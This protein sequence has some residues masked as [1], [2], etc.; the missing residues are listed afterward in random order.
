MDLRTRRVTL[1]SNLATIR[2]TGDGDT[3][4]M[5]GYKSLMLEDLVKVA[6][7]RQVFVPASGK[8]GRPRKRDY[9]KALQ[10]FDSRVAAQPFRF[11]DLSPE[12]RTLVYRELLTFKRSW[13]CYPQILSTCKQVHDEAE[14]LLYGDNL[15]DIKI[16][17][18]EVQAHGLRCG[19]Y[20]PSSTSTWQP[21][22]RV[23]TI[24]W[25]SMLRKVQWLRISCPNGFHFTTAQN[26]L[27]AVQQ[28]LY[29]L[30]I[31]L[32]D[33]NQ[34]RSMEVDLQSLSLQRDS[35]DG[36]SFTWPLGMLEGL[37]KVTVRF[38][39][40]ETLGLAAMSKRHE[41]AAANPAIFKNARSLLQ[42]A[43]GYDEIVRTSRVR[44]SPVAHRGGTFRSGGMACT[45]VSIGSCSSM[46]HG[47]RGRAARS[48]R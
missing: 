5:T 17:P 37:K 20:N 27:S 32:S 4:S 44:K 36:V 11:M 10:D 43:V 40:S 23:D 12:L 42:E 6:K 29:Y 7:T 21:E 28:I 45:V 2:D 13:T 41:A 3:T 33:G 16:W 46:L 25:P 8:S 30:C 14:G 48:K 38:S 19:N 26:H 35:A 9:V 34:L 47:R 1:P 24:K 18:S 39:D 31:F 22:G 15:I